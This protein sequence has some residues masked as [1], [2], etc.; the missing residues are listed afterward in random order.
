ME[1][2]VTFRSGEYKIEGLFGNLNPENGVVITHPHPLYGGEMYNF[3]VEAIVNAYQKKGYSTLRFNFRGVGKSQ[4]NQEDSQ[5][6]QEDVKAAISYMSNAGIKNVNLAGYSYGAWVNAHIDCEQAGI[7]HMA[8]VSPPVN[9]LKFDNV[10]S[11]PCLKLAV[12]G[13]KDEFASEELVKQMT[14]EWNPEAKIEII[15]NT[16]HFYGLS[17]R[18]L[19]IIL[20]DFLGAGRS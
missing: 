15:P 8:M 2:R 12:C 13:D 19:E 3:I 17:L 16:D 11:I 20:E 9:F 14:A 4:G 6:N 1:T 5:G 10:S 7:G 18:A